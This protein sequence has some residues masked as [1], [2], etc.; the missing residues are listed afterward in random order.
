MTSEQAFSHYSVRI[1]I[2]AFTK[3]FLHHVQVW[4]LLYCLASVTYHTSH[5]NLCKW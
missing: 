1:L 4:E 5:L 2:S 3:T